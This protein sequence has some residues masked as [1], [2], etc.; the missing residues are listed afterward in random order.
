MVENSPG[1]IAGR[2]QQ[3]RAMF[4]NRNIGYFRKFSAH[5]FG[6]LFK[7]RLHNRLGNH[8][9]KTL[10]KNFHR[11]HRIKQNRRK[12]DEEIN[13]AMMKHVFQNSR[14]TF[15][16]SDFHQWVSLFKLGKNIG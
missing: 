4:E 6:F 2:H 7:N 3:E 9:K 11:F 5:K 14:I 16:K 12:A 15:F 13:A 10:V 1:A 8:E